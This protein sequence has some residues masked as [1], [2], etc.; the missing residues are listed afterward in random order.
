MKSTKEIKYILE[1]I[2]LK[3]CISYEE[4]IEYICYYNNDL[5][6]KTSFFCFYLNR[7][8]LKSNII[9]AI[10]NIYF[11][12]EYKNVI[13]YFCYNEESKI[14]R[15]CMNNSVFHLG[16]CDYVY[17]DPR[18]NVL[19]TKNY[20]YYTIYKVLGEHIELCSSFYPYMHIMKKYSDMHNFDVEIF[21]HGIKAYYNNVKKCLN[22]FVLVNVEQNVF[23]FCINVTNKTVVNLYYITNTKFLLN[24]EL[25]S[26]Q[27]LYINFL[28]T[29]LFYNFCAHSLTV[30]HTE[31]LIFRTEYVNN[32]HAM[33]IERE[34]YFSFVSLKDSHTFI[35]GHYD[36]LSPLISEDEM[37]V[38]YIYNKSIFV[39]KLVGD[40]LYISKYRLNDDFFP[41]CMTYKKGKG[42]L[43]GCNEGYV[44]EFSLFFN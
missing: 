27:L 4:N 26:E 2:P 14:D 13:Y 16:D 21:L 1:R 20:N 25:Y 29:T 28:N 11:M 5:I 39:R 32:L 3:H 8:S 17:F 30:S 43:I 7:F 24:F 44:L 34:N 41:T 36:S 10:E 12:K 42:L 38:F 19:F 18:H 23:L 33:Y 40:E 6:L 35:L 15:I 37:Y 22:I 9:D 31:K